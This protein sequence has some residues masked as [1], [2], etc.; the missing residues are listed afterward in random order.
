ME[1]VQATGRQE[2]EQ[3]LRYLLLRTERQVNLQTS[4]LPQTKARSLIDQI[5]FF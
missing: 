3:I 1:R 5:K 2:A 4:E